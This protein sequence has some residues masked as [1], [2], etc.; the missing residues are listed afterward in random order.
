MAGASC[1]RITISTPGSQAGQPHVRGSGDERGSGGYD[2]PWVSGG[3]FVPV[4]AARLTGGQT[5]VCGN[6][7]SGTYVRFS[8]PYLTQTPDPGITGFRGTVVNLNT[9]L[10]IPN[11]HY[12]LQ[13]FVNVANNGCCTNVT[14][15]TTEVGCNVTAGLP[16]RFTAF[17]KTGN[18]P[19]GGHQIRLQGAWTQ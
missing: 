13:Y 1:I 8:N 10:T 7:V 9:G 6:P 14:G 19:P 18:V 11:S 15:S 12:Y 17:F 3:N 4:Q 5:T 16:Y 2:E